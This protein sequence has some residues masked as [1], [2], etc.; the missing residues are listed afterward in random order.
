M[1]DARYK[2]H[3]GSFSSSSF[4]HVRQDLQTSLE[5]TEQYEN[6]SAEIFGAE[7]AIPDSQ[8][9]HVPSLLTL[10]TSDSPAAAE[11]SVLLTPKGISRSLPRL[12][13]SGSSQSPLSSSG[14]I[15]AILPSPQKRSPLRPAMFAGYAFTRVMSVEE[16]E[17]EKSLISTLSQ[18]EMK[19]LKPETVPE[20]SVPDHG[21]D[22]RAEAA[23]TEA[24]GPGLLKR[25]F[26]NQLIELGVSVVDDD[27]ETE[28]ED[29]KSEGGEESFAAPHIVDASGEV[30]EADRT[31]LYKT[32][33]FAHSMSQFAFRRE[34]VLRKV[35]EG[36]LVAES[37]GGMG[38]PHVTM[39]VD[40]ALYSDENQARRRM[41][42]KN[43]QF[44]RVM[45]KF[46]DT[47]ELFKDR[48]TKQ[49]LL[50]DSYLTLVRKV[51]LL[52]IPPPYDAQKV[53]TQ[54]EADWESDS[55]GTGKMAYMDFFLS[56]FAIVDNWTET[57]NAED[58]IEFLL[59][60]VNGICFTEKDGMLHFRE[61][62]DIAY[63]QIGRA[64]V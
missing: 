47:F 10:F 59:R 46:W 62:K 39:Q 20:D 51:S 21:G 29:D 52:I 6:F 45:K 55:K 44:C 48:E 53:S 16:R 5:E 34:E 11:L 50:K 41:I 17:V 19:P 40:I 23:P 42:K 33:S 57:C 56:V 4:D 22:V 2:K 63:D 37:K 12:G 25:V 28:G 32:S 30:A 8:M 3:S 35:A 43:A 14:G 49:F 24:K 54:A 7:N 31:T 38:L 26:S 64:H 15:R 1:A 13:S 36:E 27:Y 60:L 18:L 61:D 58:Y 9:R